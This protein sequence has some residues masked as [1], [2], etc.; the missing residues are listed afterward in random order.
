MRNQISPSAMVSNILRLYILCLIHVLPVTEVSEIVE[1]FTLV[2]KQLSEILDLSNTIKRK[3]STV[4]QFTICQF[5]NLTE[6]KNQ[7]WHVLTAVKLLIETKTNA[8][9]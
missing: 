1:L 5:E 7:H 9:K 3:K 2:S 4:C 8:V 6:R